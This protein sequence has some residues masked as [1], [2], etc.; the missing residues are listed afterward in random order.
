MLNIYKGLPVSYDTNIDSIGDSEFQVYG[1]KHQIACLYYQGE[2]YLQGE[3]LPFIIRSQVMSL[4]LAKESAIFSNFEVA[5]SNIG[6]R[7]QI[8]VEPDES[9]MVAIEFN[10]SASEIFAP[11][12]DISADG[13]SV[14]FETYMFPAKLSQPG[15]ELTMTI[16]L[17]DSVSHKIKKLS[18]KPKIEGRKLNLSSRTNLTGGQ[19]GKIVITARG[20]IIAVR[21]EFHLN[22][23]RVSA[24]LFFKDLSR[25]VV[26]QY[27]SQRQSEI[28]QDLRVLSDELYSLKK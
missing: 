8:R 4:N 19:D 15:N 13:A 14:Y 25:T 26:L 2:S 1:N 16:S 11:L 12:A 17:P 22:R 6:N 18:Q 27:I 28:I 24:K 3:E 5:K 10:G 20:R 23:Y 7:T 21:P 9:L